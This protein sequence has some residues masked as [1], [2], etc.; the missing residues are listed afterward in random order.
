MYHFIRGKILPYSWNEV[1]IMTEN[2]R[3]FCEIELRFFKPPQAQLVKS[4]QTFDGINIDFERSS[5]V[6]ISEPLF[7]DDC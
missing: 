2:C 4:A 1:K 7:F 5:T 6:H 3:I